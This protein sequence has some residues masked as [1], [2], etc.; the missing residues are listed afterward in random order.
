MLLM[1]ILKNDYFQLIR[2]ISVGL[3]TNVIGLTAWGIFEGVS[4]IIKFIQK[5][6]EELKHYREYEAGNITLQELMSR[7]TLTVIE[8]ICS[9]ANL[10]SSIG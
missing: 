1:S 9:G 8:G 2:G 6:R 10:Q 3:L 7:E 5:R 4:A